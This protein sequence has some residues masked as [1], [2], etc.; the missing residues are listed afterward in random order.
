MRRT[1]VNIK[2]INLDDKTGTLEKMTVSLL[3]VIKVEIQNLETEIRA[4]SDQ[5]SNL[6]NI[7]K[8][9]NT[10]QI[11]LNMKLLILMLI[12]HNL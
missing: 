8:I 1:T 10:D 5:E 2:D 12:I 9:Y 3:Q 4:L 6:E 11:N 7:H